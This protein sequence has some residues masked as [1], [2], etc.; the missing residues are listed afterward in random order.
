MPTVTQEWTLVIE[1]EDDEDPRY[2][3]TCGQEGVLVTNVPAAA[4]SSAGGHATRPQTL[5]YE[6]VCLSCS[7]KVAL[8]S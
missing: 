7:K 4:G 8:A 3:H 2:R 6:L 5:S 1:G